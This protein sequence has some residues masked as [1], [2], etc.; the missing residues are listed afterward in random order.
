VR[1]LRKREV[2]AVEPRVVYGVEGLRN[3]PT[4]LSEGEMTHYATRDLR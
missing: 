1:A 3:T 4:H 2:L